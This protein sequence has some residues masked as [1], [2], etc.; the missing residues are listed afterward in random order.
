MNNNIKFKVALSD[1]ESAILQSLSNLKE[2]WGARKLEISDDTGIP[3]DILTVLLKRLKEA[4]K[5]ALIMIWSEETGTPN[6]SGY[7]LKGKKLG[8]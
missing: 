2:G 4:G 3:E 8:V 5:I 6:G 1:M 7:C